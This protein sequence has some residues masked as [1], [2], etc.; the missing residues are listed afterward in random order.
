MVDSGRQARPVYAQVWLWKCTCVHLC[1][2]YSRLT[3]C[4]Y[5]M[6]SNWIAKSNISDWSRQLH[7]KSDY[8]IKGL[9]LLAAKRGCRDRA[10]PIIVP[11]PLWSCASHLLCFALL[12]YTKSY[13]AERM[14]AKLSW[15]E[16][17]KTKHQYQPGP[18]H[19]KAQDGPDVMVSQLLMSQPYK[20]CLIKL[21]Q[22]RVVA[23]KGIQHH[24]PWWVTFA[25]FIAWDCFERWWVK[26]H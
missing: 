23:S 1:K 6:M 18:S 19:T 10:R 7:L 24:V 14:A 25:F 11:I 20:D 12:D 3:G 21:F 26:C 2:D 17:I 13:W 22:S 9:T 16:L 8:L 15:S 5:S 4:I